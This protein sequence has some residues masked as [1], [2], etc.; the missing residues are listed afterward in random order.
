MTWRILADN[1]SYSYEAGSVVLANCSAIFESGRIYSLLG[2]NGAG[3]TTFL[4]LLTSNLRPAEGIIRYQEQGHN[5]PYP[6]ASVGYMSSDF[7]VYQNLTVHQLTGLVSTLRRIP[8]TTVDETIQYAHELNLDQYQNY[9]I[10][11]LS[12]GTRARFH[13]F[14]SIMHDPDIVI[15]D[16][17]TNGLDPKQFDIFQNMLNTLKNRNKLI[18]MSTHSLLL[19][20]Q[21]ATD[22]LLLANHAM[23]KMETSNLADLELAFKS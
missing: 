14:L 15:L 1:L 10:K 12:T 2:E 6:S 20:A 9:P 8:K 11:S 16:E 4:E 3:K 19:S 17:P 22:T 13:L 5:V 21:T 7:D 18:I 23:R